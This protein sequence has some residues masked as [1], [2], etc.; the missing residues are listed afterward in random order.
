MHMHR[1]P[2]CIETLENRRLLAAVPIRMIDGEP[3]ATIEWQGEQRE[4]FAGRWMVQL[5]GYQGNLLEQQA[6]AQQTINA[7]NRGLGVVRHM[8]TDGMFLVQAPEQMQPADVIDE[9]S[10]VPGFRAIGP[11]F[12]YELLATPNDP[13]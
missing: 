11:D 13:M 1:R 2:S 3:I 8:G 7:A 10:A 9:L 5:D 12:R 6:R 4:M